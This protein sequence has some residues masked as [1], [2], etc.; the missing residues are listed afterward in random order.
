MS[1]IHFTTILLASY[2]IMY[3]IKK[4]R[5]YYYYYLLLL[6]LFGAKPFFFC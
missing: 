6:L 5:S 4:R 1:T 2:M 3:R